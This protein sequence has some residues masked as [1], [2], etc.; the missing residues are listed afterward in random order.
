MVADALTK[1]LPDPALTQ[2]RE[3]MLDH[4]PFYARLLH[5]SFYVYYFLVVRTLVSMGESD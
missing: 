5:L 2:Y 1:S 4:T 3:V